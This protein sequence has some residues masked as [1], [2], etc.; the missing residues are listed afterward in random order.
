MT[1]TELKSALPAQYGANYEYPPPSLLVFKSKQN[2]NAIA[3]I[4]WLML[5]ADLLPNNGNKCTAPY[6]N[7]SYRSN[8]TGGRGQRGRENIFTFILKMEIEDSTQKYNHCA[9]KANASVRSQEHITLTEPKAFNME[10]YF[11]T[12]LKTYLDS[13]MIHYWEE[14]ALEMGTN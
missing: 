7:S 14:C 2:N 4:K 12:L 8:H 6:S 5:S 10:V 13:K 1:F 9:W 3:K 11:P